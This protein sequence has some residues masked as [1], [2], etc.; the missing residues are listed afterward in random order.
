MSF[1]KTSGETLVD[2]HAELIVKFGPTLRAGQQVLI[3]APLEAVALVRRVTHHA[4]SVSAVLVTTLYI[5]VQTALM[6]F[7]AG[8]SE[9]FDLSDILFQT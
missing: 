7:R 1:A 5:D 9:S 3:S 4:L 2:K 8:L 6:R